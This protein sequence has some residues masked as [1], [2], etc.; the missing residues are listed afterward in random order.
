[1]EFG[2]RGG[3]VGVGW[4]VGKRYTVCERLE[5]RIGREKALCEAS[6]RLLF[7]AE[8]AGCVEFVYC[9][10]EYRIGLALEVGVPSSACSSRVK[11]AMA[12]ASDRRRV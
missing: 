8:E 3:W 10:L 9:Q 2:I 5:G 7:D 11:V 6:E 4:H 12:S 1:M